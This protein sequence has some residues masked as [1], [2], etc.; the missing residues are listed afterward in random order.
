[1]LHNEA[2]K[3]VVAAY[4]KTYKAQEVADLFGISKRTVYHMAQKMKATGSFEQKTSQRGL[5]PLL[6]HSA[7]S[8]IKDLIEHQPDITNNEI[9]RKWILPIILKIDMIV[10]HPHLHSSTLTTKSLTSDRFPSESTVYSV[11]GYSPTSSNFTC[12]SSFKFL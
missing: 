4:Q 6:N 5:K 2:R 7:V 11:T 12:P 1:M 10:A 9:C 8:Q 3:L